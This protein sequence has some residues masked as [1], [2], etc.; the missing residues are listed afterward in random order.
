MLMLSVIMFLLMNIFFKK[1]KNVEIPITYIANTLG[2]LFKYIYGL[3]VLISIFTTAISSG[4]GFLSNITKNKKR[5]L[6]LSFVM[7][8]T[9]III[10]QMGFANLINL[11]YPLF[12][13][14]GIV[15]IIFLIFA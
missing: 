4:Y 11:I 7:C 1:I 14:L 3:L 13:Y 10:G 2:N 5:Y 15:Q 8:S 9:S 12:G 6:A